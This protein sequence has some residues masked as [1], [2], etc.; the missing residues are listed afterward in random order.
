[1]KDQLVINGETD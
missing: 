1:M